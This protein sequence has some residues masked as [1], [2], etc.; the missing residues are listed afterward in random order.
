MKSLKDY[1]SINE[2]KSARVF[3]ED[4]TDMESAEDLVDCIINTLVECDMI[5]AMAQSVAETLD[6]QIFRDKDFLKLFSEK[7]SAA[8]MEV[9][10]ADEY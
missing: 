4:Y 2:A 8:V 9:Y 5:N 1:F 10:D 6:P 7:L 3:P